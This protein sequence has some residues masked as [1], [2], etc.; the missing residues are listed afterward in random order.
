M[1][2]EITQAVDTAT[3]DVTEGYTGI[4]E[5]YRENPLFEGKKVENVL[6]EYIKQKEVLDTHESNGLVKLPSEEAA[7]EELEHFFKK[8]GKPETPAEYGFKAPEDWPEGLDY[9]DDRAAKF[10]EMAH[11]H[12]LTAKQ[13]QGLFD[14]FHGMVRSELEEAQLAQE[15][16]LV[17]N[18]D[19]LEKVW[20][21]VDSE[22]FVQE[23]NNALRAFNTVADPDLAAKFKENPEIASNPLVLQTLARLGARMK[24]ESVPSL[25]SDIPNHSFSADSPASLD[26]AIK[27]F[28]DEGHF[29]KMI[30]E[31]HTEAGKAARQEWE[32]LNSKRL[33]MH[34]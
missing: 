11:R 33:S 30:N 24:S 21:P 12:N 31:G 14:D 27:R 23:K 13:A 32:R 6:D 17:A 9:S 25:V 22:K 8:L 1:S 28:K 34:Q 26:L 10:A 29:T 18:I 19:S 5:S 7:P 16:T 2:E 20:G 4:P 3:V 15:N